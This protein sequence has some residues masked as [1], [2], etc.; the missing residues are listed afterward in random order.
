MPYPQ[1]LNYDD[2]CLVWNEVET[3]TYFS[4][5]EEAIP[6]QGFTLENTLWT[7][8]ERESLQAD[9]ELSKFT[10]RVQIAGAFFP[11]AN[12]PKETDLMLRS[13][14]TRWIIGKIEGPDPVDYDAYVT[15]DLSYNQGIEA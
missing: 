11:D 6:S 2:D 15:L 13:N 9:A 1:N 12:V 10:F 4:K 3:V 5:T 7:T 8:I 14:G